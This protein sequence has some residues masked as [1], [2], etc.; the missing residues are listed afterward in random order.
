[1]DV[2]AHVVSIDYLSFE[3]IGAGIEEKIGR[4]RGKDYPKCPGGVNPEII[5][6]SGMVA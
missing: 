1:L 5:C 6:E 2:V 4:D 3:L